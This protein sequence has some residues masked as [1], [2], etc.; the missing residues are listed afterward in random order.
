M[1]LLIPK[2]TPM[3]LVLYVS[4]LIICWFYGGDTSSEVLYAID[5]VTAGVLLFS[6][7]AA[8]AAPK[9]IKGIQAKRARK[10]F[11]SSDEFKALK[12]ESDK[13]TKKLAEG[14]FGKTQREKDDAVTEGA[15]AY[16]SRLA[17]L[18]A[19]ITRDA[20]D[21]LSAGRKREKLKDI[22][23]STK[24]FTAKQRK[25]IEQVSSQQA[26]AERGTALNTM[27][28]AAAQKLASEN[29]LAAANTQIWSGAAE[30][31]GGLVSGGTQMASQ[32]AFTPVDKTAQADAIAAN[33][34]TQLG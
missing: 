15:L 11:E 21:P 9:I 26:L 27:Q 24:D 17:G 7:V 5:P 14:D 8:S 16:Q 6:A 12:K 31:V 20:Q 2:L 18:E 1:H 10:R 32:G 3:Q 19:A 25:D 23:D 33:M 29:Q 28:A 13:A 22:A 30:G 34:P 4:A